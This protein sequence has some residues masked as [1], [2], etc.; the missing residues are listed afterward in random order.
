S[1]NDANIDPSKIFEKCLNDL[2][3]NFIP[4]YFQIVDEIPKTISQKPLT[5][6]LKDAFSPEGDKIF[7]TDQ[8]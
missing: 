5:R 3:K 8:F 4:T 1:F 2:E 6:V 7:R